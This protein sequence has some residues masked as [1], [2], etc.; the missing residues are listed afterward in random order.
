MR[1]GRGS[2]LVKPPARFG[3]F[4]AF[5]V[6]LLLFMG[7]TALGNR[8]YA[9]WTTMWSVGGR[10]VKEKVSLD[11]VTGN[12]GGKFWTEG[13]SFQPFL[14]YGCQGDWYLPTGNWRTRVY[15][16]KQQPNGTWA[17]CAD[18]GFHFNIQSANY[19]ILTVSA[20]GTAPCGAG[21]YKTK[22][23]AA[24]FFNGVWNGGALQLSDLDRHWLPCNQGATCP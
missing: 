9:G 8:A 2:T 22:G 24:V 10:C 1:E 5:S 16:L 23:N 18:S 13:Q 21:W 7:G 11:H 17:V 15:V 19:Q 3:F 6:A 14:G 4:V 20:G 12:V